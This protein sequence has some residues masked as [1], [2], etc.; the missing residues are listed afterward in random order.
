MSHVS[1]PASSLS[2]HVSSISHPHNLIAAHGKKIQDKIHTVLNRWAFGNQ[3]EQLEAMSKTHP[4]LAIAKLRSL[5]TYMAGVSAC[6]KVHLAFALRLE[7]INKLRTLLIRKLIHPATEQ[8]TF[9]KVSLRYPN[10]I[11]DINGGFFRVYTKDHQQLDGMVIYGD[12]FHHNEKPVLVMSLGNAMMYEQVVDYAR[13][14]AEKHKVNVVLYNPRGVGLS[15]GQE[16]TLDEAVEDFK[17]VV[18]YAH[19]VLCDGNSERLA[20]LGHSLGGGISAEALKQLQDE[21]LITKIGLYINQNSFASLHDFAEGTLKINRILGR[22]LLAIFGLQ[23]LNSGNSLAT[24]RLARHT[25]VITAEN[26]QV[27]KGS[28]RL[29]QYLQKVLA[30]PQKQR[31]ME[32]VL[33][34]KADEL[35][36][37]VVL[38][39]VDSKKANIKIAFHQTPKA[40]HNE[41]N[42]NSIGEEI[43][44]AFINE[45]EVAQLQF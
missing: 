40:G 1:K 43:Q 10:T 23:P 9:D 16:F 32:K 36:E 37:E 20:V 45:D 41:W 42:F 29:S 3:L 13:T 19:R 15:L 28:S 33:P 38:E 25:A 27:M 8:F 14:I 11:Y 4:D 44:K 30:E 21:K 39:G 17:A 26:D 7:K 34:L 24:R 2:S 12:K 5:N 35:E 22:I 6:E 31:K 18:N